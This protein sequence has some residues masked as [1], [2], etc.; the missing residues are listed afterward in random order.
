VDLPVDLRPGQAVCQVA[1][2]V[3]FIESTWGRCYDHNFLR[4]SPIFGEKN[5][6]F[7]KKQCYEQNYAKFSFVFSQKRHFFRRFFCRKY[8]KNHNIGP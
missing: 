5:G 3:R 6:V 8:L 1:A 4:F 2:G 7:L